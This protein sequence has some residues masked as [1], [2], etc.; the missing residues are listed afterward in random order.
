MVYFQISCFSI[1]SA[2]AAHRTVSVGMKLIT[3]SSDLCCWCIEGSCTEALQHNHYLSLHSAMWHSNTFQS[4]YM[5]RKLAVQL[6]AHLCIC[7][8]THTH[9]YLRDIKIVQKLMEETPVLLR[10]SN[11]RY[12]NFWCVIYSTSCLIYKDKV[13][14]TI[15]KIKKIWCFILSFVWS[16]ELSPLKGFFLHKQKSA[17]AEDHN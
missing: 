8:Q 15:L 9:L 12:R 6:N 7:T 1:L 17:K 14:L 13:A 4:P 3:I 16:L 10:E 11:G 2:Q 5:L